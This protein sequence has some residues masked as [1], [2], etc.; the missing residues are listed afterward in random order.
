M[1]QR[2]AAVTTVTSLILAICRSQHRARLDAVG[3]LGAALTRLLLTLVG[4]SLNQPKFRMSGG[5]WRLE[6]VQR[7][8]AADEEG[9]VAVMSLLVTGRASSL[10]RCH[11]SSAS[12]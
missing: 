3:V 10:S 11:L 6:V 12:R 4:R 7:H 1:V 2:W 9:V 8:A 5:M